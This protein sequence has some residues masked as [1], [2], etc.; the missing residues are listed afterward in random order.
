MASPSPSYNYSSAFTEDS[1]EFIDAE[2]LHFSNDS[3][4]GSFG[5]SFD[6]MEEDEFEPVNGQENL[7]GS[8]ITSDF[9]F[10]DS[11]LDQL[12]VYNAPNDQPLKP[13]QSIFC[14]Q[15]KQQKSSLGD[16]PV[17]SFTVKST[18]AASHQHLSV[19]RH[20]MQCHKALQLQKLFESM[21]RT[22]ESRRHVMRHRV[23]L[24]VEQQQVI[25]RAKE[26]LAHQ[27]QIERAHSPTMAA[28]LS[29]SRTTLT[30][31]LE[32]SRRQLSAYV[33]QMANE[34]F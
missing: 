31:G 24:T 1:E 20:Q 21:K 18:S 28:F 17:H 11:V 34:T 3:E 5:F 2:P 22:E 13:P 32:Q 9:L 7:D 8:S 6:E 29:G 33:N 30:N 26:L 15:S 25:Y 19:E 4:L 27:S 10:E 14:D 12:L 23:M 16:L